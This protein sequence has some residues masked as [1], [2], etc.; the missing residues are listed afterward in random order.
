VGKLIHT[1]L[2]RF[3]HV[4]LDKHEVLMGLGLLVAVRVIDRIVKLVAP[5]AAAASVVT[6]VDVH[7]Q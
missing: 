6:V 4:V 1:I 3:Q 2:Q 5:F 7:L